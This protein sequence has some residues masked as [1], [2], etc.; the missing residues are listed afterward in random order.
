ML[1]FL[2]VSGVS[3]APEYQHG[4]FV[5]LAKIPFTRSYQVGDVVAFQ[6]PG[7]GLLIKRVVEIDPRQDAYRV[8][9]EHA[10]SV[11][12]RQFGLVPGSSILGKVIWH[13]GRMKPR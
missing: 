7:L 6:Q 10:G 5:L 8:Q 12:S 4:D 11:D 3:L 9:G 1:R 2:R 13:L